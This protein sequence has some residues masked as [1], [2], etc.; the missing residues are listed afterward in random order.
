MG[1]IVTDVVCNA[2]LDDRL[3]G[4]GGLEASPG[5]LLVDRFDVAG[6][7]RR[8]HQWGILQARSQGRSQLG[9]SREIVGQLG[10]DLDV[11]IGRICDEIGQPDV[12]EDASTGAG[13]GGSALQADDGDAHVEGIEG[14]GSAAVGEGVEGDIDVVV[15]REVFA[16]A[17]EAVE[18]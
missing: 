11:L 8:V 13:D 6:E 5:D 2:S 1:V 14:G 15:L 16:K 9:K 3:A 10:C 12:R 18:L 7:T 17:F 4:K